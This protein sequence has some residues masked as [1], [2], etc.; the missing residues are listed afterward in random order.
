MGIAR[1]DVGEMKRLA[2]A[3]STRLAA[4]KADLAPADFW[5]PYGTLANLEHL[6]AL[7]KGPYRLFWQLAAE[8]AVADIGG[9]DGDLAFFLESLGYSVDLIENASTNF[10]GLRG[11]K[12]L[13]S[14]MHSAVA[15]HEVDLDSQFVLPRSQYGLVLF[16]GI[17]Y[18]LKNPYFALETLARS[19]RYCLISTRIARLAADRRTVIRDIPVAYLLDDREANNDPT[20][21]WIL[22]DAGLRRLLKRT[23]WTVCCYMTVG[24]TSNSDPA[25]AEGDERAFCLVRSQLANASTGK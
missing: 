16:L 20:N 17:L 19:A 11:A 12:L 6:D 25:S 18:H 5:Y 15:I 24:N 9:A 23:G 3:F 7:L 8:D 14:A 21:Y 4:L 10:N 1:V 2:A 13:K 22:S